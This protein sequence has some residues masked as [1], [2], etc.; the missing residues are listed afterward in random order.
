MAI[1]STIRRRQRRKENQN[2]TA[3]PLIEGVFRVKPFIEC[4]DFRRKGKIT[5]HLRDGRDL[6]VPL[7]Y[8]PSIKKL[9]PTQRRRYTIAN[10]Q[11][12]IFQDCDEVFHVMEFLS[13]A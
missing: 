12:I 9:S 8:F 5:L 3:R 7:S 6:S 11:I 4:F 1:S 13:R 2:A 10:E